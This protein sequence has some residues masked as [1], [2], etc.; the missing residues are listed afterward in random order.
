MISVQL[1]PSDASFLVD[2]LA[3]QLDRL[4]NELVHTDD[5]ALHRDLAKD[6]DHLTKVRERILRAMTADSSRPVFLNG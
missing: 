3:T 6:I 2:Q 1:D 5:R 4:Q